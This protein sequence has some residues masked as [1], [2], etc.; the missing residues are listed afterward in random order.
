[1]QS[2]RLLAVLAIAGLAVMGALA[3]TDP[4]VENRRLARGINIPGAFDRS[5]A[6]VPDP[7]MKSEYF[8]KIK[9]AGFSHVRLVIRFRPCQAPRTACGSCA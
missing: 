9:D 7:P 1:M 8:R 2:N 6:T 4:F 5:R 3:Q